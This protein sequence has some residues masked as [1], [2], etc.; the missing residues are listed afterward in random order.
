MGRRLNELIE[1]GELRR[2]VD[3]GAEALLE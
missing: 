3:G 1:A 2:H